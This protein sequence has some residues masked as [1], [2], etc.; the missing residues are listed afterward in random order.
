[1]YNSF[2]ERII[3]PGVRGFE[4]GIE[5]PFHSLDFVYTYY[6][7]FNTTVKL[8]FQNILNEDKEIEQEG[9]LLR[10]ETVGT[11]ISASVSYDF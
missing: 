11:G 2:G 4:D 3:A 8:K 10:R 5:N 7:D 9:L 6:P 1:M